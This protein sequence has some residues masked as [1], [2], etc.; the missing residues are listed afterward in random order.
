MRHQ[1]TFAAS[2]VVQPHSLSAMLRPA[3]KAGE[4]S[5]PA[6]YLDQISPEVRQAVFGNADT[7]IAFRIGHTDSIPFTRSS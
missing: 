7:M 4:V 6:Q 3:R 1:A 2:P 5:F